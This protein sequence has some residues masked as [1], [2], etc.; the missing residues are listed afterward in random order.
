MVSRTPFLRRRF[1]YFEVNILS[2]TRKRNLAIIEWVKVPTT[3][4]ESVVYLLFVYLNVIMV[5][6]STLFLQSFVTFG[7]SLQEVSGWLQV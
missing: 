1:R 4:N 6:I 2:A 3:Q 5:K 7:E